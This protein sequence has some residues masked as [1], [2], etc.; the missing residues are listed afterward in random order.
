MGSGGLRRSLEPHLEPP[1]T[2][3]E[4]VGRGEAEA[5]EHRAALPVLVGVDDAPTRRLGPPDQ[6]TGA[7]RGDDHRTVCARVQGEHSL[8]GPRPGERVVA[9]TGDGGLTMCLGELETIVRLGLSITVVVFND[10]ALS[11]IEV[12]QLEG[13]GGPAAV[14]Y[15]PTDFATIAQ[16]FGM[17]AVSATTAA[18]VTA[19]MRDASGPT[20]VDAHIDP[21]SYRDLIRITRG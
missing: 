2:V 6:P 16:G 11:L 21:A 4:S 14:K 19:A 10:S 7:P 9:L 20:L 18:Q 5:A 1:A 8:L 3:D 17:R 13:H 12:K 15:A